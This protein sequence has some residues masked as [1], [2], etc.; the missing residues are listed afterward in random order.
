MPKLTLNVDA[1]VVAQAKRY[2]AHHDTSV[3]QMVERYLGLVGAPV[4]SGRGGSPGPA[5]VAWS[6]QGCLPRRIR[7]SSA[8]EISVKRLLLDLNIVLDVVLDRA[9]AASAA[10]L[11]AALERGKGRG[12][13]P[14]HGVTT[15]FYLVSRAQGAA[16]AR[17]ATDGILRTFAVASVDEKVLRRALSLGWPDFEDAVCASAAEFLRLRR[18]R[19]PRSQRIRGIASS[20]RRLPS[21]ARLA[22]RSGIAPG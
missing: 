19:H 2:A 7:A 13:I 6:G 15:I 5:H 1:K 12:Y 17:R 18:H 4:T 22:D 3:S 20:N 16:F 14:A 9:E 11:W 8:K 10:R 21:R